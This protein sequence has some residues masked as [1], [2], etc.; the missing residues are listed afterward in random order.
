MNFL[1][2]VRNFLLL[3]V[4]FAIVTAGVDYYRLTEGKIPV[5]C[6][7]EYNKKTKVENYRGIFYIAE[8]TVKENT[9]ETLNLS[10]NIKYRI[11]TFIIDIDLE[12]PK[13][14]YNYILYVKESDNCTTNATLYYQK[15]KKVY[16]DCLNTIKIKEKNK[17]ESVELKDYL[18]N[19]PNEIENILNQLSLTGTINNKVEKYVSKEDTFVIGKLIAYRCI[20]E[21]DD[22]YL[23]TSDV[24][25]DD[26]CTM[27]EDTLIEGQE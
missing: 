6:I 14:T 18:N 9:K 1:R 7:K 4:F 22:I 20:N 25:K 11:L 15:D 16:I 17:K 27:K 8:R 19:N 26:Y 5:F 10:S 21:V 2:K 23:T 13:Q 12:R 24:L 3:F